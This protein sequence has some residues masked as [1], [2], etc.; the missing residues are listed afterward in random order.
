MSTVDSKFN[1]KKLKG[2]QLIG[3]AFCESMEL[4]AQSLESYI[5]R[6]HYRE[7]IIDHEKRYGRK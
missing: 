6:T 1:K 7:I 2:K 4:N 3:P 5:D